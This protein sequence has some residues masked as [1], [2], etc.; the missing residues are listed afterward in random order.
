MPMVGENI[1]GASNF[2]TENICFY[3]KGTTSLCPQLN[4]FRVLTFLFLD[5]WNNL[6]EFQFAFCFLENLLLIIF[7]TSNE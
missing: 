2:C 6:Y 5:D 7:R 1:V 3:T 4:V